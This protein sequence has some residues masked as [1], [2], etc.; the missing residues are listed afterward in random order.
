[1]LLIYAV[2]FAAMLVFF[3]YIA[4]YSA[5][6][7]NIPE[8]MSK[9]GRIIAIVLFAV[10]A[11]MVIAPVVQTIFRLPGGM[12]RPMYGY[13]PMMRQQG[14]NPFAN[15]QNRPNFAVT[16]PG[17]AAPV[18]MPNQGAQTNAAPMSAKR[19]PIPVNRKAK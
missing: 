10:A 3:G 1:M 12:N 15:M 7:T 19:M 2:A 13:N 9:F 11:L 4:M 8:S 6:Q 5:H 17:T 16:Q 14:M 18:V